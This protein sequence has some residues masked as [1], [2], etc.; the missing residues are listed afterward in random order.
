MIPITEDEV[1]EYYDKKVRVLE[2]DNIE[3]DTYFL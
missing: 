2:M 3:V 1:R